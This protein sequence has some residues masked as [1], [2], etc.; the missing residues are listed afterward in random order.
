MND[1]IEIGYLVKKVEIRLTK[2]QKEKA[3]RILNACHAL[4]NIYIQV[5]KETYRD[6]K[7]LMNNYEFSKHFNHDIKPIMPWFEKTSSKALSD[8]INN[9]W[10]SF[11]KS[12]RLKFRSK[13][14]NPVTSFF[15][16]KDAIHYISPKRITIPIL[17]EIKLKEAGYITQND[18]DSATSGRIIY[19]RSIDCWY[20]MLRIQY[21]K[22]HPIHRPEIP[23]IGIDLGIKSY[24]TASFRNASSL[25]GEFHFNGYPNP[26]KDPVS[27][28]CY[29][30]MN[31]L[32]QII[33]HKVTCNT[34]RFGYDPKKNRKNIR[35]EDAAAIYHSK[36][37]D[38]LRKRIVKIWAHAI[39]HKY[40]AYKKACSALV[41]TKPEYIC[42]ESID[43]ST[44]IEKRG[45]KSLRR[46][47][48]RNC[49]SYFRNF[50]KW[51]CD[52]HNIP[53]Y[54]ADDF[55]PSTQRCSKCGHVK[56]GRAKLK[57]TDREY[58]CKKCG[59]VL[60]RD[61]NAARNIMQWG[62]KELNREI[63][64]HAKNISYSP[65]FL[66]LYS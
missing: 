10:N 11:V 39:N 40:D 2:K 27:E 56:Q 8:L 19:K 52:Q 38:K 61:I 57:L 15:F 24:I 25:D 5:Q 54:L 30:K 29:D 58:H 51:K 50:M 41:R 31:H 44:L 36:A 64:N 23:G 18:V 28:W 66:E 37:I 46:F 9:C 12:H 17:G 26:A 4:W 34:I 45:S 62:Y 33:D 65:E 14:K 53:F 21:E 6:E 47:N 32:N 48:S 55:Y 22:Q 43:A 13:R 59:L 42:M 7:R 1:D 20:V 16:I 49:Y 35:K 3:I 63:Q 60:D